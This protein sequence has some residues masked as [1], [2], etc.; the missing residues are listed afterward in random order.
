[1]DFKKAEFTKLTGE[2]HEA[3]K[4]WSSHTSTDHVKTINENLE[5]ITKLHLDLYHKEL[6]RR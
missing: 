6:H 1:M 5:E 3:L 2:I 4:N